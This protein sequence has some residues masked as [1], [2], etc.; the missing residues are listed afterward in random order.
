MPHVSYERMAASVTSVSPNNAKRSLQPRELSYRIKEKALS[1]GF[2][3][4][5]IVAAAALD[6]EHNQW[7]EWL[8]RGYHGDMGWMARDPEMR[9][10]Q[11]FRRA[12]WLS[13]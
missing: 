12:L 11:L 7:I 9:D 4:V 10:P 8:R 13:Q 6:N 2:E 1:E 3:K 5:G